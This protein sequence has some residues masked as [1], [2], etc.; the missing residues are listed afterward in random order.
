MK[1]RSPLV[2]DDANALLDHLEISALTDAD[3]NAS[4]SQL[5][6]EVEMT[7]S[8]DALDPA[9][10]GAASLSEQLEGKID[11]AFTEAERR[12]KSCGSSYPF[13]VQ[14]KALLPRDR[15]FSSVYT[16][17]LGLSTYGENAIPE[18][19]AA[20]LFEETCAHASRIYFGSK[21]HP[22][23]T[24]IFG[25]PR[26][27]GERGFQKALSDLCSV[28]LCEGVPDEK[29]PNAHTKKDAGLDIVIWRNFP[30]SRSSK[31]IAFG[32]CATGGNWWGK[33]HEL[34]PDDWCNTWLTKRPQVT[35]MKVFFVPHAVDDDLWG[36]LGYTAGVIFD[37]FRIAFY[38]E[39]NLPD[40]LRKEL[41][42][43]TRAVFTR[44]GAAVPRRK[45]SKRF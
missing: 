39:Q 15:E 22:A 20:K 27:I 24:H 36:E 12:I 3:A 23:A 26:R 37:R 28:H 7:G 1:R 42:R 13:D 6:T 11:G 44:I 43:W 35:P 18:M 10:E 30:D 16:F 38:A 40:A 5:K 8:E 14:R 41:Q 2:S 21:E 17:L 31:F 32:Q 33:R 25:F 19:D 4:A 34:Q 9:E 29:M 45:T